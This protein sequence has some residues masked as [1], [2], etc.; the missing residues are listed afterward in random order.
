M[1]WLGLH[2][3]TPLPESGHLLLDCTHNPFLVLLAYLVACAAGFGTLDMA[4]RV[5][6][7][8][9]PTAKRRWRWIGAACLAGGIWSTHFISMLAFQAPIAIHYEVFMTVASLLIAMVASL[10]AMQTLS[11]AQLHF[12]QYLVASIWMGLGI[13]L[14]HYV[15]MA[16]MRSEAQ[17]YFSG[18][19]FGL[20][21]AIA[22]GASLAALLLSHYLRSGSGMFH[23]LLK[24]GASLV[25]GAGILSMHF[26][27]MAAMQLLLPT[28]AVPPLPIDNNPT[29]LGLS[30]AVITLLVIGSSI[31]AALADKKLQHK[32]RDLRRVNTL[33]SE[34]DQARASL[35]QV[36]HYDALTSLLNRR[37]F[38][39]IFAEKLAQKSLDGGMLAVIFLD[40]DHF[41]RINDSLGHDAGDELLT[42]LAGHIKSSVRSH[43]DVV[44]RFG[45]DEF[46]ILINI[47]HRDEARH[48]A[49][50]IMLKMKEP[51]ELAGRRMVMTTS[52]GISVFPED[53]TT[54][55]E[56]LK[57]A[58][59][60]LYQS[61]DGGRNSLNFFSSNLKTRASLE[62]QLE[63]ELRNALRNQKELVLHYQPILDLRKGKVTRLE[64]LVRWQHPVHGL[65]APDRFIGI[66]E[67]N[68]L[69]AELDNWVLRQACADLSW[70]TEQGHPD[71]SMAVNCSAL[72]LARDE[73][74]DE[75]EYALRSSGIAASRLELEVT[76][77][78]LMGNI[79]S[80]LI[81]LR[82]I[83]ALGVSLSIDDFGTGYSSLS[84]LKRLPLNTLKIDRSFIQDIPKSTTDM[85]IV[86]A[87]IGMAH[88]LHL[89][90][91]TEGV[92]TAQQLELLIKHGCDYVQGY[93]LSA[94]V[95]ANEV[96]AL[97]IA[98]DQ[99][100]PLT[101]LSQAGGKDTSSVVRPIR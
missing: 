4:E 67:N 20:S 75:I 62:L 89:Q 50:R 14:M 19:L 85:E 80:T 65:L 97:I 30:V 43:N 57:T 12:H 66:A 36:A 37:G 60:A 48:M 23:Q 74:A 54:S 9:N 3:F 55:E 59:L 91:I 6:H 77:N 21:V 31:S 44:A 64:A 95:P 98:L 52:I 45:G 15:G 84:Y 34:L 96:S 51:I 70:L 39:Q 10:F 81:L 76:E 69:I 100:N 101:P 27:G 90:V 38:N 87:I 13:A 53:G 78:A 17:V 61:K 94:A 71:L 29:Q 88:T 46:C 56:L 40:I 92:E 58:D 25:L 47:H 28:G 22:I 93:L 24:Y 18:A 32:E 82:Q 11:H 41:K 49:Q 35:Q 5:G 83:R 68:G 1:E 16:A 7:V 73:L 42:V 99:H 2:F 26:T 33:L 72:N 8:D 86:Q 63:E 79:S